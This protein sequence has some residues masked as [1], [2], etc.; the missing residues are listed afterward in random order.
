M[1]SLLTSNIIY[2][3]V[4]LTV[5]SYQ[6]LLCCW[7]TAYAHPSR[8]APIGTFSSITLG[9][10]SIMTAILT[11][12]PFLPTSSLVALVFWT[13]CIIDFLTNPTSLD[14]MH[15]CR[16][17]R[18]PSSSSRFTLISCTCGTRTARC[19]CQISLQLPWPQFRRW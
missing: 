16:P 6:A 9:L 4:M 7:V 15:P 19:S 5:P 10:N 3:K 12:A 18:Q 8:L 1:V 11:S 17:R 13:G 14:S 2:T